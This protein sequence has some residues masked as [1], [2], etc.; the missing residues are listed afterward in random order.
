MCVCGCST[1][2]LYVTLQAGVVAVQ[3]SAVRG[4]MRKGILRTMRTRLG[5]ISKKANL[6]SQWSEL[7]FGE[8]VDDMDKVIPNTQWH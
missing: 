3:C 6:I 7:L 1:S 8:L 2:K 4:E 5:S